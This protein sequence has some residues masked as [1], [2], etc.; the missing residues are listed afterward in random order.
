MN[1]EHTG[2]GTK[3]FLRFFHRISD[4]VPRQ[5]WLTPMPDA[6][7]QTVVFVGRAGFIYLGAFDSGEADYYEY[8]KEER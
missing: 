4:P 2:G 5:E 8:D 3:A 7:M 1:T 6:D